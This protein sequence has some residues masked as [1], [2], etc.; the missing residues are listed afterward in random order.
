MVNSIVRLL[1]EFL[2]FSWKIGKDGGLDCT[3]TKHLLHSVLSIGYN[4]SRR[5]GP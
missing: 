5:G 4:G 3:L 1:T 2:K